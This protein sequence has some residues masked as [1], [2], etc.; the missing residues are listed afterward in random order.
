V[1]DD[2]FTLIEVLVALVVMTVGVL[3]A[4]QLAGGGLRLARASG[5]HVGATLLASAKLAEV[6][7]DGAPLDLETTEGAEGGYRWTRRVAL[8]P[9]LLPVE[10]AAPGAARLRLARVTVEVARETGGARLV[11]LVTLRTWQAAP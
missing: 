8:D 7:A 2:G 9:D 6:G 11:E 4:L 1:R 3:T 5:D 10:P